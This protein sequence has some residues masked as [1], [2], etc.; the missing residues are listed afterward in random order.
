MKIT[1][2]SFVLLLCFSFKAHEK[3]N[4]LPSLN[5]QDVTFKLSYDGVLKNNWQLV[6]NP[7]NNEIKLISDNEKTVFVLISTNGIVNQSNFSNFAE[8][9]AHF[10]KLEGVVECSYAWNNNSMKLVLDKSLAKQIL[11]DTFGFD[12]IRISNLF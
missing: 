8:L 10:L 2:L 5:F 6:F 7:T 4:H 9:N 11:I 12:P 1:L 3:T